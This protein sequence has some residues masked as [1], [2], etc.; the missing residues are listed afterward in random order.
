[1]YAYT[2]SM[3]R[4][5]GSILEV[6]VQYIKDLK[7]DKE[8]LTESDTRLKILDSKYQRLQIKTMVSFLDQLCTGIT[9]TQAFVTKLT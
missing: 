4:N 8:K 5:K 2:R 7:M 1:M 6:A 9:T 3:K